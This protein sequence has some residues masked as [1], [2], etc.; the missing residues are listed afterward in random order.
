MKGVPDSCLKQGKHHEN[1]VPDKTAL[2]ILF[3]F[4]ASA[5]SALRIPKYG[6]V[7]TSMCL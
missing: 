1:I 3:V 7:L 4:R 2:T 5:L 6:Q